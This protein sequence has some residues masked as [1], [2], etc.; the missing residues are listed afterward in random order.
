MGGPGSLLPESQSLC[1]GPSKG[2]LP[3]A[4]I[5]HCACSPPGPK[6]HFLA[7]LC[8]EQSHQGLLEGREGHGPSEYIAGGG[9][10]GR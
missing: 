5:S 8:W 4:S 1:S 2:L 6:P 10:G 9:V 3:E 7:A